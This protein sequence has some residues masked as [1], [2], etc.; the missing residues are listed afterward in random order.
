MLYF[1]S[2][3]RCKGDMHVNRDMYGTYKECL[4]CGN[5]IDIER[6]NSLLLAPI[7]Q[8]PSKRKVA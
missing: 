4:Q 6:P 7:E 3:P 8:P 1:R 2:C 5:M